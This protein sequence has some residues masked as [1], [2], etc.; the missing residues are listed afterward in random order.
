MGQWFQTIVDPEAELGEAEALAARVVNFLA[1][2]G[3]ILPTRTD[4]V[5]CARGG[6]PPGPNVGEALADPA[7]RFGF[8]SLSTNGLDVVVGRSLF[9]AGQGGVTLTCNRCGN[10]VDSLQ[11][12]DWEWADAIWEWYEG[13]GPGNLACLKCG[14]VQP[15]TD[16]QFDPPWGFGNLGFKFWNWP[17]LS[18]TFIQEI[19]G[20]L[21]HRTIY[22]YGK[23]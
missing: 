9:D 3:V 11:S 20:L 8:E 19:G 23:L 14:F 7:N 18:E 4:C 16:W 22:N 13:T 1:G 21:G 2:R 17:S 5:L 6:Y 12:A 10:A 15:I